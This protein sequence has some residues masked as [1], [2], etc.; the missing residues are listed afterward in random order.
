MSEAEVT[1]ILDRLDHITHELG[2]TKAKLESVE[3]EL[4]MSRR[5]A[6]K[7]YYTT[8]ELRSLTGKPTAKAVRAWAARKG[9]PSHGHNQWD[10]PTVDQILGL[11]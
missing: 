7:P 1:Q 9:I 10:R 5:Q 6:A 8:E 4:V 3:R 2:G 11:D